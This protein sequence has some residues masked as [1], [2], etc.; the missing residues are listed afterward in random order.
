MAE[1]NEGME[2]PILKEPLF[3]PNNYIILK[4][5]NCIIDCRNPELKFPKI[6]EN[7]TSYREFTC[8]LCA[9][10]FMIK[11]EAIGKIDFKCCWYECPAYIRLHRNSYYSYTPWNCIIS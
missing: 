11:T 9:A 3:S 7:I 5:G 4:A 1:R 8:S 10:R 6:Q 2:S